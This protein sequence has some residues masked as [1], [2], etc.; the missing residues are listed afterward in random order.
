MFVFFYGCISTITPPVALASYVAAG[1]A[2][3]NADRV[4]WT[5]FRFGTVSFILPFM[6]VYGPS[7]SW[8]VSLE[9]L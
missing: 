6:F 8:R 5:A 1:L 4:G 3:A 7:L 9:I 2:G